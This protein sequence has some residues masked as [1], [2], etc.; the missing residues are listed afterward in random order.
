MV[1]WSFLWPFSALSIKARRKKRI[2]Y[3]PADRKGGA[4]MEFVQN[5]THPDFQAKNFTLQRCVNC[6]IFLANQ[7]RKCIKY[8]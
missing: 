2:F 1:N 8:Q 6:D 3:G 5:F 7:Q 4:D